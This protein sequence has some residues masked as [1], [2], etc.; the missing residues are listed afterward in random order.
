MTE[1]RVGLVGS[2]G[3]FEAKW[4]LFNESQ[5]RQCHA[6]DSRRPDKATGTCHWHSVC[7]NAPGKGWKTNEMCMAHIRSKG[8]SED[9][10]KITSLQLDHTCLVN[11]EEDKQCQR[12]VKTLVLKSALDAVKHFQP[13]PNKSSKNTG[14]AKQC[15]NTAEQ[16]GIFLGNGAAHKELSRK[17]GDELH[18]QVGQH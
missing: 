7:T 1:L 14:A 10:V 3:Q 17:H 11:A 16:A 5:A 18:V 4:Y 13:P 2:F 9:S 12:N 8:K 6:R 15:Q